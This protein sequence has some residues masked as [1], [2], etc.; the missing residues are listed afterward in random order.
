MCGRFCGWMADNG[1]YYGT[2]D[3]ESPEPLDP[4]YFCKKHAREEYVKI[5]KWAK[6]LGANKFT[7]V[8]WEKPQW[9]LKGIKAAG[10]ELKSDGAHNYYLTLLK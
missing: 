8:W 10:Y 9:Y 3:Y 1:T 4:E 6:K 5:K 7:E 2:K